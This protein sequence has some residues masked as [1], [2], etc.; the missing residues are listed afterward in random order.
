MTSSAL[1]G[2]F[3]AVGIIVGIILFSVMV[4]L[5]VS[6]GSFEIYVG[7]MLGIFGIIA[8][9]AVLV[10]GYWKYLVGGNNIEYSI[11]AWIMAV[12]GAVCIGLLLWSTTMTFVRTAQ[13]KKRDIEP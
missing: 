6:H 5:I 12:I 7:F 4:S 8:A 11:T 3:I 1:A 10:D 9:G 2:V 13:G